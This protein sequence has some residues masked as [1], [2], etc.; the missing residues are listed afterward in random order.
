[1][2]TPTPRR[3]DD[4]HLRDADLICDEEIAAAAS[5]LLNAQFGM[6]REDLASQTAY[7]LGFAATGK[8]IAEK[9]DRVVG[10]QIDAGRIV[11]QDGVCRTA[12]T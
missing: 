11:E 6:S 3:R 10:Q 4:E 7:L 8:R 1:M 2:K 5:R 12:K 9:I